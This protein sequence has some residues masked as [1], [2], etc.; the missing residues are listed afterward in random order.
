[1]KKEPKPSEKP[2]VIKPAFNAKQPVGYRDGIYG[3]AL[4][5]KR[6]KKK[7]QRQARK[8]GR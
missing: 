1:M 6:K 8:K 3:E 7:A 2:S 4:K 5:K